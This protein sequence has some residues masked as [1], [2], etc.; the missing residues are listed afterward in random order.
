MTQDQPFAEPPRVQAALRRPP[1]VLRANLLAAAL[2]AVW[3]AT[4]IVTVGVNHRAVYERL[5]APV[6]VLHP[7]LHL[8]LPWPFSHLRWLDFGE[9]R[10]VALAA[11]PALRAIYRVGLSDSQA[12]DAAYATNDPAALVGALGGAAMR[13]DP[14]TVRSSLQASL[15]QAGSGIEVLGV[16]GAVATPATDD[17]V[18]AAEIGAEALLDEAR[19]AAGRARIESQLKAATL[20]ATARAKAAETVASARSQLVAFEAD[21]QANAADGKAFL[22]ERYFTNLSRAIGTAPKTII[23][24]RLNWPAAPELDL[25]PPPGVAAAAGGGKGN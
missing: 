14:E 17:A 2:L 24:H 20:V 4:G 22:L 16:T 9:V 13:A 5:G 11:A 7:G 18:R 8:V 10:E 3:C 1:R 12:M 23:D 21:R 15:D 19:G 6:A 25:R